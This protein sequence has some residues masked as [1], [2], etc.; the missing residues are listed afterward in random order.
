MRILHIAYYTFKRKFKNCIPPLILL[1][2]V[3]I[4]ILG[5]SL[6]MLYEPSRS[7]TDTVAVYSSD[8]KEYQSVSDFLKKNEK[9][10]K[11]IKVTW[12]KQKEKALAALKDGKYYGV[13]D[14]KDKK[15]YVDEEDVKDT[16]LIQL[17]ISSYNFSG[18]KVIK[19]SSVKNI[20]SNSNNRKPS[21][22]DYYAVT[23]LVMIM[24]Y[25]GE[26]GIDIISDDRDIINRTVSLPMAKEK[27]VIGKMLGTVTMM[28]FVS[29]VII[30]FSKFVYKAYWGNNYILLTLVMLL[31]SFLTVNAGMAICL[32]TKD[33]GTAG[34]ITET[35]VVVFTF[36]SGGYLTT[37]MFSADLERLSILSP[38]YA[39]QSIIFKII[40][41][42]GENLK[43]FYLEIIVL[44]LLMFGITMLLARRRIK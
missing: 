15:L 12:V 38:S 17:F 31:F 8:F 4:P 3:L 30:V 10:N 21:A 11:H 1:P 23:M 5:N 26:Y 35:L 16:S 13:F 9:S 29:I 22:M 6:K 37:R 32:I 2:L 18:N 39:E 44:A 27:I 28:F 14:V 42:Y 43:I 19:D 25:G 40:Y 24:W 36:L 20:N 34:Y 33:R 41:G 7:F